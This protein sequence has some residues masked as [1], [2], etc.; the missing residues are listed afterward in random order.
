MNLNSLI[1]DDKRVNALEGERDLHKSFLTLRL[2]SLKISE[3]EVGASCSYRVRRLR[4]SDS[5][6]GE[7]GEREPIHV[8]YVASR[9]LHLS[10]TGRDE[11]SGKGGRP[12]GVRPGPRG[13][14]DKPGG[15]RARPP[16]VRIP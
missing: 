1:P 6:V 13:R 15:R 10:L 3:K 2:L 5:R 12:Q 16:A 4:I 7:G 8:S 14:H 11:G 9:D